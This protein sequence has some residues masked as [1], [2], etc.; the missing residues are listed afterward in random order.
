MAFHLFPAVFLRHLA[1]IRHHLERGG[2]I[3]YPTE[4]CYGLGCDPRNYRAVRALQ[5]LKRRPQNKG[6]IVVG[7]SF[8]QLRGLVAPLSASQLKQVEATW[9][10]PH[11]WLLPVSKK[12]PHWLGG[13]NKTLAARVTAHSIAAGLC[14]ALD[15]ALVSTSANRS[16]GKAA[17]T[18]KECRRLFGGQVLIIPGRIGR[19]RKPSTIQDLASGKIVRK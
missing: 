17:K 14:H 1:E 9:P 2:L 6:L 3:A 19:R 18:A 11:T 13:R 10:G 4:S 12:T 15:M 7:Y 5:R 16:G 8:S